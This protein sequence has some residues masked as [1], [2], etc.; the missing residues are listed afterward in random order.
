V[1]TAKSKLNLG[2]ITKEEFERQTQDEVL[3]KHVSRLGL[4]NIIRDDDQPDE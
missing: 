3:D 1:Y 2:V 4:P